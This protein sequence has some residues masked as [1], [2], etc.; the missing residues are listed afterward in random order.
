MKASL[1]HSPFAKPTHSQSLVKW[2]I[3]SFLGLDSGV[4][5]RVG[6]GVLHVSQPPIDSGV[7]DHVADILNDRTL[8]SLSLHQRIRES[9][10]LLLDVKRVAEHVSKEAGLRV[11]GYD[12]RFG[13]GERL[14]ELL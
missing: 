9:L 8:L 14:Q 10:G 12:G 1:R 13:L 4:R 11:R 3:P 7:D 5:E 2:R 6:F